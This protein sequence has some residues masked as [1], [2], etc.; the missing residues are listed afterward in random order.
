MFLRYR[1]EGAT[2]DTL[3]EF[4]PD[5]TPTNRAIIAE[6]LYSKLAG[7]RRTW[8][9][10]KVEAMQGGIAARQVA[11][12]I[13]ITDIHPMHRFEDLPILPAGALTLEY[14]KEELRRMR[15]GLEANDAMLE[16]EKAAALAQ[17]ALEIDAAEVGSD[18]PDPEPEDESGKAGDP[19]TS[20]TNPSGNSET[21]T[22]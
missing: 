16:S 21:G 22:G 14:S 6:K 1:P 7:E 2:E 8:E 9:Q 18:E 17:L 13:A 12:W 3:Y 4:R 19:P 15:A 11:L 10:L 20:E 5:R